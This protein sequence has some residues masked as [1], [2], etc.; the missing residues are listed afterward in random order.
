MQPSFAGNERHRDIGTDH[1]PGGVAAIGI[2]SGR[3]IQRQH[4][5]HHW[6]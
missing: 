6:R 3:N 2:Q 5:E 4:R 1:R